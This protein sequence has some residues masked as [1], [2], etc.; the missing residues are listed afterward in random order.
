VNRTELTTKIEE[1]IQNIK[2]S[3]IIKCLLNVQE[4]V[5]K[6]LREIAVIKAKQDKEEQEKPKNK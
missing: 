2:R 6:E 3:T 4:S 5:E 1:V